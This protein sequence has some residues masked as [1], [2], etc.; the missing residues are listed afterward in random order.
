MRLTATGGQPLTLW[1]TRPRLGVPL[2]NLADSPVLM[3]YLK[4]MGMDVEY[5]AASA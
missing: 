1:S 4:G 3:G 5:P 2:E